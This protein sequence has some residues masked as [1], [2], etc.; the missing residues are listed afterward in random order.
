MPKQISRLQY[1]LLPV[2]IVMQFS[3][4]HCGKVYIAADKT[5]DLLFKVPLTT[6]LD[7]PPALTDIIEIASSDTVAGIQVLRK[8][9]KVFG[10]IVDFARPGHLGKAGSLKIRIDSLQTAL[11]RNVALKTLVLS[12]TG[13]SKKLKAYLMLPL[14]GAGYFVK[15]GDAVLAEKDQRIT[16]RTAR[17]EEINF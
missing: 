15:G 10:A 17:F 13:K 8:G 11:G 9:G 3:I 7:N 6:K 12:A 16:V 1:W 5:I 14:L 2:V 4:G